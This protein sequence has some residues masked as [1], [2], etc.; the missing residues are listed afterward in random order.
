MTDITRIAIVGGGAISRAHM[1]AIAATPDELELAALVDNNPDQLRTQLDE[2]PGVE[3]F[4]SITDL[5]RW[6][7]FDAA[8]VSTP[9]FLHFDNAAELVRAG[10][11]VLVEKPLCI[12]TAE[13]RELSGLADKSGVAVVAG[14]TRRHEPDIQSVKAFVDD[15]DRF[16][17]VRSFDLQGRQD[18]RTY[19]AKVGLSHW[20]LDGQRSG[21]GVTVA[22]GVHA[23]DLMRFLSGADFVAVQAAAQYGEPFINGAESQLSGVLEL[24]NGATGTLQ[25]DYLATRT[26]FS[27]AMTIIGEH[28]SVTQHATDYGQWRGPVAYS[29]SFDAVAGESTFDGWHSALDT[30]GDV[31]VSAVSFREQLRHFRRVV[32]AEVEPIS[33]IR[34]NFNTVACIEALMRSARERTRIEVEQW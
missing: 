30:P 28:G 33:G 17:A 25:L 26:P 4:G 21:G 12:S 14:Q 7:Q 10:F 5:I 11:P 16:G 22:I 1:T 23:I 15:P 29:T 31:D 9:H 3:G 2:H 8:V 20:L 32:R 27:E 6:G 13:V 34:D 24:A 18:L 19:V